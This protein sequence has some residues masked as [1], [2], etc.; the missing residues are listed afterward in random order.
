MLIILKQNELK[1]DEDKREEQRKYFHS[2]KWIYFHLFAD[3][4]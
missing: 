3:T 2:T 4:N 1:V